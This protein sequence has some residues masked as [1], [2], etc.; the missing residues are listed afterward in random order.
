M[1]LP[2]TVACQRFEIGTE[3]S[4]AGETSGFHLSNSPLSL[5]QTTEKNRH[6]YAP[7]SPCSRPGP[8]HRER[9]R[10][11]LCPPVIDPSIP[12]RRL[13]LLSR[14]MAL[15][16]LQSPG[17]TGD[18][19]RSLSQEEAETLPS[20]AGEKVHDKL[21]PPTSCRVDVQRRRQRCSSRRALW[22]SLARARCR[23]S[24]P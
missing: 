23:S 1:L 16:Q 13:L 4:P 6:C 19:G 17:L 10:P 8:T 9:L 18:P 2:A 5:E 21:G 14:T 24:S 7:S 15:S 22:F 12:E 11:G 3:T 20:S